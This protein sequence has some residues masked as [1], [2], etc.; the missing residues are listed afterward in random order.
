[1]Y[2]VY[3]YTDQESLQHFAADHQ[4]HSTS[5]MLRVMGLTPLC[6]GLRGSRP[7]DL[8]SSGFVGAGGGASEIANGLSV[9]SVARGDMRASPNPSVVGFVP[10]VDCVNAG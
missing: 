2:N 4:G 6:A 1:M 9:N 3:Q 8:C 7:V 10:L 5:P